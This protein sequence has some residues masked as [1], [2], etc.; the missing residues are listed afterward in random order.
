MENAPQCGSKNL[1]YGKEGIMRE[2]SVSI[3][4]STSSTIGYKLIG[5]R[6]QK[7]NMIIFTNKK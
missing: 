2:L 1:L 3:G 6:V 7:S 5:I 4:R